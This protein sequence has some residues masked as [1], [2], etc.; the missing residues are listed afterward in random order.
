MPIE[1]RELVIRT[2]VTEASSP[3]RDAQINLSE[4]KREI[5]AESIEEVREKLNRK[6]ER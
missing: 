2:T 6:A 4:V 5:I 1:I 3:Q